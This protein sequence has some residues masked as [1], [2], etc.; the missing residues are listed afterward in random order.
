MLVVTDLMDGDV[1]HLA[2]NL[3]LGDRLEVEAFGRS[4]LHSLL[5]SVDAGEWTKIA[6]SR[7]SGAPVCIFGMSHL[8][9]TVGVPWMLATNDLTKERRSFVPLAK[10]VVAGMQDERRVL[11]NI[12]DSRN[13]VAHRWLE[14]LGFTIHRAITVPSPTGPLFYTFSRIRNVP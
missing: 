14:S 13:V 1:P 9:D 12:T 7:D 6:R 2:E 4:A 3:R 11:M 10:S 8:D 5:L